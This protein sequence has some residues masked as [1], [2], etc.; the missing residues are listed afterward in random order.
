MSGDDE[1]CDVAC[2]LEGLAGDA[3]PM[4]EEEDW[5][6]L[7]KNGTPQSRKKV[8]DITPTV[9]LA[10]LAAA[11][12]SGDQKASAG[13]HPPAAL[14]T[15][16]ELTTDGEEDDDDEHDDKMMSSTLTVA[17]ST[18]TAPGSTTGSPDR[19]AG[20][21]IRLASQANNAFIHEM[22]KLFDPEAAY[23]GGNAVHIPSTKEQQAAAGGGVD[24]VAKTV[25]KSAQKIV[26]NILNQFGQGNSLQQAAC[27]KMP[28]QSSEGGG[29]ERR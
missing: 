16:T 22:D 19:L 5:E 13:S 3:S 4:Q 25:A 6:V 14:D 18:S 17:T 2:A 12:G 11:P 10:D 23:P 26:G 20:A 7:G 9:S 15:S 1:W 27:G 21:A 24:V 29:E 28:E 8:T